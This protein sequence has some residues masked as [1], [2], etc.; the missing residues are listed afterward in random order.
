[1]ASKKGHKTILRGVLQRNAGLQWLRDTYSS[2]LEGQD[3]VVYFADDD[4][5]YSDELFREMRN[6]KTVSVW[7]V[8]L[9]GGLMVERPKVYLYFCHIYLGACFVL[10]Y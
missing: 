5:T 1:M 7:P 8:G 3:G 9:S 4:N 6:T 10:F 2:S